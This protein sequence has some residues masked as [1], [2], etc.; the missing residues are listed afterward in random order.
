VDAGFPLR[1]GLSKCHF[2]E[3]GDDVVIDADGF[4]VNTAAGNLLVFLR[5]TLLRVERALGLPKQTG[6][7]LSI[8]AANSLKEA[9]SA[10]DQYSELCR[11]AYQLAKSSTSHRGTAARAQQLVVCGGFFTQPLRPVFSS[12]ITGKPL[13][14]SAMA[15]F[16]A[17]VKTE[18]LRTSSP[19]AGFFHFDQSPAI[20]MFSPSAIPIA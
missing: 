13:W 7:F 2:R 3:R 15:S 19:F 11:P 4:K 10:P 18:Q 20:T 5:A 17:H 9:A 12:K 8:K 14:I 6:H 1:Q 16:G